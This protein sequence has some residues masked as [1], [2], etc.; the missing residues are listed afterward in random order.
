MIS[1]KDL[2]NESLQQVNEVRIPATIKKVNL[3]VDR[4]YS[5]DYGYGWLIGGWWGSDSEDRYEEALKECLRVFKKVDAEGVDIKKPT[6]FDKLVEEMVDS[7]GGD[8]DELYNNTMG[9]ILIDGEKIPQVH[10]DMF[11]EYTDED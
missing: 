2:L 9:F 1:L 4:V 5:D 11:W 7:I 8:I 3:D 10:S 6:P